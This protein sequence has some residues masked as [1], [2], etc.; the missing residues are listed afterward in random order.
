M[1]RT[2][3]VGWTGKTTLELRRSARQRKQRDCTTGGV[4]AKGS[5]KE[6]NTLD[7]ADLA[8]KIFCADAFAGTSRAFV[9]RV[10]SRCLVAMHT[11]TTRSHKAPVVGNSLLLVYQCLISF[12]EYSHQ[13]FE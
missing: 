2:E 8:Y 9:N 12:C 13:L 1:T 5:K 10:L 11:E 3:P 6:L 7:E 4:C